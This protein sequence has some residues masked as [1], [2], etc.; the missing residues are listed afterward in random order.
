M[1]LADE[2]SPESPMEIIN[3]KAVIAAAIRPKSLG[4]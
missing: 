2:S 4:A 1:R 3:V